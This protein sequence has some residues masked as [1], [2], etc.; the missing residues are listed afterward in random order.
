MCLLQASKGEEN[1]K[2]PWNFYNIRS[3]SMEHFSDCFL[4]VQFS[5]AELTMQAKDLTG[6]PSLNEKQ[7]RK[8]KY[9]KC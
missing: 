8:C 4:R 5:L 9:W 2:S 7:D 3:L 6:A 1:I